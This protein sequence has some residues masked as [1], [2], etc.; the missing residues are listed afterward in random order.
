MDLSN[1]LFQKQKYVCFSNRRHFR[2]PLEITR[3]M[4][5]SVVTRQGKAL[6]VSDTRICT[7]A[8]PCPA[9]GIQSLQS[10]YQSFQNL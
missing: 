5:T 8:D 9:E 6:V 7:V 10:L 3:T 2:Y 4:S 1:D